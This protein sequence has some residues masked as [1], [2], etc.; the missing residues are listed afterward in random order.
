MSPSKECKLG[1]NHTAGIIFFRE[2]ALTLYSLERRPAMS[3]MNR[4]GNQT[5]LVFSEYSPASKA[6][7]KS[8]NSLFI[9]DLQ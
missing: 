1:L 6:L 4:S 7:I 8:F 3:S 5:S 9:A 2:S